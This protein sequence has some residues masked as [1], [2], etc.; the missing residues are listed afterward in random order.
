[1]PLRLSKE[2]EHMGPP[3]PDVLHSVEGT[4]DTDTYSYLLKII[5]CLYPVIEI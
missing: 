3:A 4:L 5:R 1:M 2:G